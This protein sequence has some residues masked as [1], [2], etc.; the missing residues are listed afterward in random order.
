MHPYKLK[1]LKLNLK[2]WIYKDIKGIEGL[3]NITIKMVQKD[4][5]T[6]IK[7]RKDIQFKNTC[8]SFLNILVHKIIYIK[9]IKAPKDHVW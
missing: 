6:F 5:W 3:N 8:N 7:K 4:I 1:I 2:N 9:F